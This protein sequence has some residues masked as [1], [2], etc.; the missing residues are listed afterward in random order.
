MRWNY[1]NIEHRRVC[2]LLNSA[3]NLGWVQ[4]L[5]GKAWVDLSGR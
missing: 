3:E 5:S 4:R 2:Y 1:V